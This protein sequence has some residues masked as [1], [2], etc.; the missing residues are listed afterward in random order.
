MASIPV[1]GNDDDI[2]KSNGWRHPF[3]GRKEPKRRVPLWE[4]RGKGPDGMRC[5][6]CKFL[7]TRGGTVKK[8]FKCSLAKMKRGRATDIGWRDPACVKFS[9]A[10]KISGPIGQEDGTP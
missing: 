9:L 6:D 3:T 10:S 4:L 2:R 1:F 7:F 5:G 8:Y